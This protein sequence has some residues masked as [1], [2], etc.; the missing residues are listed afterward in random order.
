GLPQLW[1][2]RGSPSDRRPR[3]PPRSGPQGLLCCANMPACS[4]SVGS[5]GR[6]FRR[7]CAYRPPGEAVAQLGDC[8]TGPSIFGWIPSDGTEARPTLGSSIDGWPNYGCSFHETTRSAAR[9]RKLRASVA[10]IG[11]SAE[12]SQ[13]VWTHNSSALDVCRSTVVFAQ[14]AAVSG[15]KRPWGSSLGGNP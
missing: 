9:Q 12:E 2:A 14:C 4:P 10:E 3:G 15:R 8:R 7:C 5:R 6:P 1:S 13:T 11:R